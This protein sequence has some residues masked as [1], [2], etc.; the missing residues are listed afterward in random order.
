MIFIARK[1]R[2]WFP[3]ALYHIVTRGN[4]QGDIFRECADYVKYLNILQ[5]TKERHPFVLYSYCLMTNHVHLQ[6]KTFDHEIWLIMKYINLLYTKYFNEKYGLTGHLFQGRYY[7][8]II[9]DNAYCMETSRYIHMNPVN[10]NIVK[11]PNQ[12]PWSSYNVYMGTTT[13]ELIN[14]DMILCYFGE[15]DR[16]LYKQFVEAGNRHNHKNSITGESCLDN[17]LL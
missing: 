5:D 17:I 10:A 14:K 12:Y 11:K 3:G 2:I 15:N 6:L 16:D 4:H 9:E 13:S 8:E 1:K 7:A